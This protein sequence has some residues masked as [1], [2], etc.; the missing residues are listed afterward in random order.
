MISVLLRN[1]FPVKCLCSRAILHGKYGLRST[2]FYFMHESRSY[3]HTVKAVVFDMGGVIL[4]SPLPAVAKAEKDFG[5]PAG[6][7]Q[8]MVVKKYSDDNGEH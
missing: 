1:N 4:P 7:I 8:D 6:T 3:K 5:L 2:S